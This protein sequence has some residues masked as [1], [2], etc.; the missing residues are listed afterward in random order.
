[1]ADPMDKSADNHTN[2]F[3]LASAILASMITIIFGYDTGVMSGAMLFMKE[4]LKIN[5]T[6]V[7]VLAGIL[8]LCAL[9]GSLVAGRTSDNIGRRWTI[10][11]AA[12]LFM[13]GSV[14]MGYG[15]N[16]VVLLIGRCAAGIGVGFALMVA[17]VY[18]AEIA[19]AK[20]RGFLSSLPELGI[21]IGIFL[22]YIIN[23]F[24]GKLPLKIGWRL[25]LGIAAV[26]SLALLFAIFKMPESPRWLALKGRL[27]HAKKVLLKISNS[28][29]EAEVRLKDIKMAVG[30][31]ENCEDDV[32]KL[33]KKGKGEGVWKELLIHP[34]PTVRRILIAAIG[35]HFFEHATGIEAVMLYSPRIFRK[36]GITQREKL[37]LATIGVGGT[38]V[39][40][41]TI[42]TFILD[43]V[44]RRRLLLLSTGGMICA[45]AVLGISLTIADHS[46]EKLEWA[47]IVSLVATYAFVA[48]FNS[49]LGPV[50]WVYSSEIW[51]LKLRAQGAG[52]GV[53]VNR[54]M[55]AAVSMSFISI[56]T[57]ITIGGTFFLFCGISAVAWTFFFICCPETKEKS[58]EEIEMLFSKHKNRSENTE[59]DPAQNA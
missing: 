40:F 44:G 36:A 8:N 11:I 51:P 18:S 27:G 29:E 50:T 12:F 28:Q 47:L 55:N 46:K 7:Q 24:F 9:V 37:L 33:P 57:A 52:V 19:G 35:I 39:F 23:Y 58:L 21:G 25:M 34:T 38:K 16:F 43:R 2:K 30:I 6:Q 15:P 26:P 42:A 54:L 22:G 56:Y 4:E 17:P 41:L 59:T 48:C 1:M 10:A 49:G 53:A 5:D 20:T 32:V 14:L 45:L 13:V 3:A 31:D